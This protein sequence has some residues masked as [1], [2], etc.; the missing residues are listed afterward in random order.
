V[1]NFPVLYSATSTL[2]GLC[3]QIFVETINN[4]IDQDLSPQGDQGQG[5]S[6]DR[7]QTLPWA[8]DPL[9]LRTT[10]DTTVWGSEKTC[11]KEHLPAWHRLVN[12]WTVGSNAGK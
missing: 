6:Q 4:I 12:G 2:A 1:T 5:I 10:T 9:Q 7:P 8:Q 11:H 3:M